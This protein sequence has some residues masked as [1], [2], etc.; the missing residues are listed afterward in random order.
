MANNCVRFKVENTPYDEIDLNANWVNM[1]V[2]YDTAKFTI[3]EDKDGAND[4]SSGVFRRNSYIVNHE[5][6]SFDTDGNF[7]IAFWAKCPAKSEIDSIY[8]CKLILILDTDNVIAADI[9]STVDETQWHQYSIVRDENDLITFRVDG[10][11][12]KEE[13][14]GTHLKLT[15]NS[16]VW[17]GS[18]NTV[19]TGY[20]VIAD[21]IFIFDWVRAAHS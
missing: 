4:N 5:N 8:P 9:P 13:T 6:E 10:T 11:K 12:F 15:S 16:Y 17:F 1:N 2:G 20:D 3:D 21:D 19:A 18:D 14:N 7:T